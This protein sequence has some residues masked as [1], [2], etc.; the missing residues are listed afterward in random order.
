MHVKVTENNTKKKLREAKEY[1]QD[2]RKKEIQL[3]QKG[4]EQRDQ[5]TREPS[6]PSLG[7]E[8]VQGSSNQSMDAL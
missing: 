8:G 4:A 2:S 3:K 6:L 1:D 5:E 7:E